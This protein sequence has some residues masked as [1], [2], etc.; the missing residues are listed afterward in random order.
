MMPRPAGSQAPSDGRDNKHN[1]IPTQPVRSNARKGR[2]NDIS[3]PP[4]PVTHAAIWCGVRQKYTSPTLVY[5]EI[6][7]VPFAE[8]FM[9]IKN[10]FGGLV[11]PGMASL[12][13]IITIIIITIII[14]III[15][16]ISSSSSI[17]PST[18]P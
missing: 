7:F 14:I 11:A 2:D 16:I 15:I 3:M 13:I 1:I 5:G 10:K 6:E 9:K 18:P 4:S 12:V 8:I 17:I